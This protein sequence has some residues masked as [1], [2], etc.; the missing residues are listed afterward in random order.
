MHPLRIPVRGACSTTPTE[1]CGCNSKTPE[2][3]CLH[4]QP[5]HDNDAIEERNAMSTDT[6]GTDS[7]G[8]L[9]HDA[10]L[11]RL[12]AT[13][14]TDPVNLWDAADAAVEH[15]DDETVRAA[16]RGLLGLHL[17][18]LRHNEPQV[19]MRNVQEGDYVR[20]HGTASYVREVLDRAPSR[21]P[22]RAI[23]LKVNHHRPDGPQGT[24]AYS[25]DVRI[26]LVARPRPGS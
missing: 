18:E 20:L 4:C 14:P 22:Q 21:S 16:L 19:A 15:A 7:Q 10:A 2:R 12:L 23:T 17:H 11:Q 25:A 1:L 26:P 3:V 13:I 6:E 8:R 24:Y 9:H 5:N